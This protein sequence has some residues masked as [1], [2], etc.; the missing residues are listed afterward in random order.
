[1]NVYDA[2]RY[3]GTQRHEKGLTCIRAEA[4]LARATDAGQTA[5]FG[6]PADL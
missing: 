1:M 5:S 4:W 6:T 2:G 3:T